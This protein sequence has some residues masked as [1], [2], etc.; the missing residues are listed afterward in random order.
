MFNTTSWLSNG[1][2]RT[3]ILLL[4]MAMLPSAGCHPH[5]Y[6]SS[7]WEPERQEPEPEKKVERKKEKPKPPD[8]VRIVVNIRDWEIYNHRLLN[9]SQE[10]GK[11]MFSG[12]FI[13]NDELVFKFMADGDY[14]NYWLAKIP[15]VEKGQF[16]INGRRYTDRN[17]AERLPEAPEKL[18]LFIR[19]HNK[20]I[21]HHFFVDMNPRWGTFVFD[22][23]KD[24]FLYLRNDWYPGNQWAARLPRSDG[25]WTLHVQLLSAKR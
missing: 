21:G 22:R 8:V 7:S 16:T 20:T 6:R 5:K 25:D 1:L 11:L 17:V 24:G 23:V 9:W 18:E 10:F 4:L 19:V 3:A 2:R 15:T 12:R 14:S 13:M